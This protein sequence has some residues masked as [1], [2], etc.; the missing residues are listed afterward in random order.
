MKKII[1]TL[2]T[3]CCLFMC[4]NVAGTTKDDIISYVNTQQVGD[5]GTAALFTSYKTTFTRLIKQKEL[6][7]AECDKILGYLRNSIGILQSKGVNKLSDMNK[8]SDAEKKSIYSNLS[9]G[10][11]IIT[12]A[13]IEGWDESGNVE[14]ENSNT[15]T[16]AEKKSKSVSTNV[17]INS[18]DGTMDIYEDGVLVD[19]VAINQNKLTYTGPSKIISMTL[20]ITIVV[21]LASVIPFIYIYKKRSKKRRVI[22]NI[23]ISIMICSLTV[24]VVI[25]VCKDKIDKVL[26]VADMLRIKQVNKEKQIVVNLDKKITSYPSYGAKYASLLINDM[27]INIDVMFGDST[28][29][30]NVGIGHT[31]WSSFPTEGGAIVYSGHNKGG[32]L[33]NIKDIKS[34]QEIIVDTSYAKCTY[35][36]K[37]TDIIS[38]TSIDKLS[39]IDNNE[40]LILYTCYPFSNYIYGNK[41]FVVY[42]V[43]ENVEWK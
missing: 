43:L 22:K 19:K 26:N 30:L 27:D 40:T 38:D 32:M 37:K 16:D 17:L 4:S 35:V 3:L 8:L 6:S 25:V 11:K 1:G 36:V 31:S 5:S 2:I 39:K 24:S 34:G 29:I 41:R 23:L 33:Y 12:D 15:V 9:A 18:V 7:S 14:S 10:A 28:A 21:F 13:P 42:S 20:P